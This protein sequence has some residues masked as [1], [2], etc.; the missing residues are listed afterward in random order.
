VH[1]QNGLASVWD[2]A[3]QPKG[4]RFLTL[5]PDNGFLLTRA[6]QYDQ[7]ALARCAPLA[8]QNACLALQS[9]L[10]KRKGDGSKVATAEGAN[11]G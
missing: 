5:Q 7:V 9:R 6:E 11:S 8:T 3:E 4:R 1:G 2:A 10:A